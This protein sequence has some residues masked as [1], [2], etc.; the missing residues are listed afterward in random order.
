[1]TL[2]SSGAL[3]LNSIQGEF[4][5]SNPIALSEYYRGGGLVPNHS[6][7]S[8][9][10]TSGVIDVQDFYGT[11]SASPLDLT[12][13]INMKE[14]TQGQGKT[15]FTYYGYSTTFSGSITPTASDTS[16]SAGGFQATVTTSSKV[17]GGN[18]AVFAAWFFEF[19]I[20]G[21]AQYLYQNYSGATFQGLGFQTWNNPSNTA[22]GMTFTAPSSSDTSLT[23]GG[24][25]RN[26]AASLNTTFDNW[27]SGRLNS[28]TSIVIS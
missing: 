20:T 28:N 8:S 14:F 24:L 13:N 9:I 17:K 18:N 22:S 6:N 4:G 19:N 21:I 10:P 25:V 1:M 23:W 3:S 2:P 5:G 7:T 15:I 12:F 27:A 16:V 11:S 26:N